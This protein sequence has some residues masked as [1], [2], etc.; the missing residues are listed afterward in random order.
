[1]KRHKIT[2]EKGDTCITDVVIETKQDEGW[3]EYI[4]QINDKIQAVFKD[5]SNIVVKTVNVEVPSEEARRISIMMP[6]DLETGEYT[7]D[8][9][10][11]CRGDDGEDEVH[12]ICDDNIFI[13]KEDERNA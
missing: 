9:T 13:V 2:V 4:P 11:V 6:S 10:L 8:V 1:M 12:T 3:Y 5:H 7:Y